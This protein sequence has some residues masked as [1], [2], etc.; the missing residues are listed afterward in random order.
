MAEKPI[1]TSIKYGQRVIETFTGNNTTRITTEGYYDGL[2]TL[3]VQTREDIKTSNATLLADVIKCLE[4]LKTN[5]PEVVITIKK[6]KFGK[7]SLIQK[8]WITKTEKIK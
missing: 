1:A 4:L 6:D 5:T 2:S 3:K 8:L 7:P